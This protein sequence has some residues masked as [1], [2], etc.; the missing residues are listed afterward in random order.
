MFWI[1][2]AECGL[3]VKVG[4]FLSVFSCVLNLVYSRVL[5]NLRVLFYS[6]ILACHGLT[7]LALIMEPS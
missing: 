5:V 1:T 6:G 7:I 3:K 4:P 2:F